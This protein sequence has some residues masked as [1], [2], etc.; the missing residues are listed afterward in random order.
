MDIKRIK[1]WIPIIISITAVIVSLIALY[2]SS[3]SPASLEILAG[4]TI[5]IYH[6]HEEENELLIDIPIVFSNRGAQSGIVIS[7]GLVI[8]NP[9]NGESIL[10][11]GDRLKEYEKGIWEY[12]TLYSPIAIPGDS[13]IVQVVNFNGESTSNRW[14][15]MPIT[16]DF[17]LIGW[18]RAADRPDIH[19]GF[20][21]TFNEENIKKINLNLD[22]SKRDGEWIRRARFGSDA[23][24]L[25]PIEFNQLV[26]L[27]LR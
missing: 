7:M 6:D 19:Y 13:Q 15:P 24:L 14:I 9:T 27:P 22:A 21:F 25:S 1:S 10:L 20:Q 5:Q 17:Y 4:E 11:K 23:R 8:R 2:L 18:T 26:K 16:Y 3:L 12:Q